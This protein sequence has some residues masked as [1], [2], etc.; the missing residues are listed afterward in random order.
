MER[1]QCNSL[2]NFDDPKTEI[3]KKRLLKAT[4][5]SAS[6]NL[7]QGNS[8]H[9][10]LLNTLR[11]PISSS[12][13]VSSVQ[14]PQS[15]MPITHNLVTHSIA[16]V[17]IHANNSPYPLQLSTVHVPVQIPGS[18][19]NIN[20]PVQ[21][22]GTSSGMP[23]QIAPVSLPLSVS[24]TTSVPVQLPAGD[25][26]NVPLQIP[27]ANQNIQLPTLPS[28]PLLQT[29]TQP[30]HNSIIH[31]HMGS[32]PRATNIDG[33]IDMNMSSS[34][35]LQLT[36]SVKMSNAASMSQVQVGSNSTVM[37]IPN[38]SNN[39]IQLALP[40]A[41]NTGVQLRGAPRSMPHVVYIQTPTG[42]KPVSS[43]EVIS[44]ASTSGNPPQI[45]VRRP[46][47]SNSNIHLI[48]NVAPKPNIAPKLPGQNKSSILAPANT[49][50]PIVIQKPKTND[51]MMVPVSIAPG[52][53]GKQAIAYLSSVKKPNTKNITENQSILISSNQT[54][55]NSNNQ[56]L[57]LT[58]MM[59]KIQNTKFIVPVTLP[60]TMASKGPIINLQIANGQIQN[61]PQGNITVMRDTTPME[62]S[63]MPPLAKIVV[64]NGKDTCM[65]NNSK[66]EKAY[67]VSITGSRAEPTGEQ[68]E[69]TLSIPETNASMNDDIYTVSIAD[70]EGGQTREKSF[71][72][73]IPEKGKSLL[74]R[75]IIDRNDLGP[76]TIAAPAILR[77]SNSDNSERKTANANIKRR[78]SLCTENLSNKNL[79][80]TL[81][82]PKIMNKS[83]DHVDGDVN[84]DHRV[85]SLFCDEK[86]DKDLEAKVNLGDSDPEDYKDKIEIKPLDLI[87]LPKA[88]N[89]TTK[90]E[91]NGKDGINSKL[92]E[93][94]PG[95]IW[96]N[97][98]A[99]LRG[100]NLH[101]QTNEFGL[102][103][104]IE[105]SNQNVL[106][107][108]GA[109]YHTPLKQRIERNRDKK[110]TSPE[111][112]YRCDGCGC[113]GMAAE[114]ITP[115]ICSLTCQ[116]EVQKMTQKKKDKERA[117]LAKKR[118]KMKKLLMR[119]QISDSDL[120][121]D[122]DDKIPSKHY[123]S[124]SND[125]QI[126]EAVLMKMSEDMIEN[127]KYPWMCGKNGFS[128]MRYLDVC[129]A[130]A[131]PVKLFRDP[132]PY[133]KNNFKVG[134][135][136]EAIDPQHPSLFC[137][138]SVAEVQGYRMRLHFD[139]YPDMYDFWVNADS[140][141]IFPPGWCEKNGRPLK[142]PA[143]Y[144]PASFSWPLYLKQMRAVA[145]PRQLFQH[146]TT[147]MIK[148]NGFRVGMK[149]EAEDRQNELV[150]VA[151][152]A[153]MLDQRLLVTFD[154][155]DDV[156]DYWVE[157]S[158]PYVHPVGWAEDHG[159]PLTPPNYYK[160]PDT[161]S[162]ESY[163]AETMSSAAP[164]RAFKT[165]PPIGFKPGM[166]LEVVDRRV[167]FL[168]RVATISAV[169]GHQVRVSFDGWPEE[170]ACWLD[171]DSPDIHPVGWCLK[172]GHP[173]EPP[174]TAEELRILGPCGVG[175]C[176]GLG[177]ARGGAHKQHGA[178]SACPY[179]PAEPPPLPD[180]LA[181]GPAAHALLPLRAQ[182]KPK[183]ISTSTPNSDAP[184]EK[185]QRGRPPKHKR[186]EEVAK[187][188]PVS[189]DESLSSS[190]GKRWR[191]SGSEDN[192]ALRS[193]SRRD[194]SAHRSPSHQSPARHSPPHQSPAHRSPSHRMFALAHQA[195]HA[196]RALIAR[197][198]ADLALSPD[199]G[200]WTQ[201]EV[202]ALLSRI[203]GATVGAA[204]AAARLSGAELVMASCEELVQ[205]LRLRLGPAVKVYATV[206]HLRDSLS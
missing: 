87:Y 100:S 39:P 144:D 139:E 146:I 202:A 23:L 189:D 43:T 158:S 72:L 20:V 155:W 125:N 145:A 19:S 21:L 205:C 196:P 12:M 191:G 29:P 74:N 88:E 36:D 198:M 90:D 15:S 49:T 109:K 76:V 63:E 67:A 37:Q 124:I 38:S 182:S 66:G 180:R 95:L 16:P 113:H 190:G 176:R 3:L 55:V 6:S 201:K 7:S 194:T 40:N 56:K 83:K 172:T 197:H 164:P 147:A 44:Q 122:K 132:F 142:P 193:F 137:V 130:K 136:M 52:A 195:P 131:A 79:K 188:E 31:L 166:K 199:P 46:I 80:L 161:F 133:S 171:D 64:M 81:P 5:T 150:C 47:T 186:V 27:S 26:I 117:E 135:R 61:D 73:A 170:L 157:P 119:K 51:K 103:D 13:I 127:E 151:S 70:D 169:K 177:S 78:I 68:G 96:N 200:L 107:N 65:T 114:F 57:Y 25:T 181:P 143:G 178:A 28:M 163:L 153:D 77:R 71:T 99:Q 91:V 92:E 112:L 203:A 148:P 58:P 32:N 140:I 123:D 22:S 105:N 24:G 138:V 102:I 53:P 111:D 192:R 141:D 89:C 152:V 154:S 106:A 2:Q 54:N 11:A 156:Y 50:Q 9:N 187:N 86:L 175:G 126:S 62:A 168:I 204:A 121:Q 120:L 45:I 149:L 14:A 4:S 167:P 1:Q 69:Y 10:V 82:Q 183:S 159:L 160:D 48:S 185:P 85:P 98:I 206:R 34:T 116:S 93:D 115:N 30:L 118:N 179:R 8:Q 42:L 33:S 129:K 59:P 165:R 104:L 134:M 108:A 128:W 75:N 84:D 173:L 110:P 94:P 174:L 17:K 162:W 184:K 101:F 97:G 60:A 35:Q 41:G 18:T